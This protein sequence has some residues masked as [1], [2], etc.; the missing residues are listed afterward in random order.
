MPA[1]FPLKPNYI[2]F[3]S[4]SPPPVPDQLFFLSQQTNVLLISPGWV[5]TMHSWRKECGW[6]VW[7]GK[8]QGHTHRGWNEKQPLRQSC[9]G[10]RV[11]CKCGRFLEAGFKKVAEKEDQLPA[12]PTGTELPGPGAKPFFP[13]WASMEEPAEESQEMRYHMLQR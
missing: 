9:W 8:K 3:P 10:R 11:A 6:D 13:P 7:R 2:T 1:C 4:L 5:Y 12:T